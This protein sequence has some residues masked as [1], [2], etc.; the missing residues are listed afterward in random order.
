MVRSPGSPS[1]SMTKL[2]TS[3]AGARGSSPLKDPTTP[4]PAFSQTPVLQQRQVNA[5][6]AH[7]TPP[8]A[9]Q[10]Q[11]AAAAAAAVQPPRTPVLNSMSDRA[12]GC[13]SGTSAPTLVGCSLL[14]TE[15][16]HIG[17]GTLVTIWDQTAVFYDCGGFT[18]I[19]AAMHLSH[20]GNQLFAMPIPH[21]LARSRV[22]LKHC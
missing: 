17:C 19:A 22:L 7:V 9:I 4:P 13:V 3:C 5:A 11:Q 1:K 6:Q 8:L 14:C 16:C 18:P 21:S 20:W 10:H 15:A 2:N 12:N